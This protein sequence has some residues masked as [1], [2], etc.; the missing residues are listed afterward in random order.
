MQATGESDCIRGACAARALPSTV[1]A[2][3]LTFCNNFSPPGAHASVNIPLTMKLELTMKTFNLALVSA[4]VL[5]GLA[6][7]GA[8]D[9]RGG[10]HSHSRAHVGIWFGAPLFPYYSPYYY[11]RYAYPPAYYYPPVVV[12]PPAPPVYI[13]QGVAAA[14]S[15]P[16]P[17]APS[18]QAS[19][20]YWYYCTDSATYYPYV[21]QCATPW[22]QV[23]PQ[24]TPPQQ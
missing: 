6:L 21:Q 14:P 4:A 19:A 16:A 11:P 3:G 2:R 9:A 22:Q 10:H 24:T 20:A 1:R 7:P 23:V 5:C 18:A 17:A 13:E 15:A 8:A 12:P